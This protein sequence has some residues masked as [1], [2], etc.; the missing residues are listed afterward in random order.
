MSYSHAEHLNQSCIFSGGCTPRRVKLAQGLLSIGAESWD[1]EGVDVYGSHVPDP[2]DPIAWRFGIEALQ[3]E[4]TTSGGPL[5]SLRL[6]LD[7]G[8]DRPIQSYQVTMPTDDVY[9][10]TLERPTWGTDDQVAIEGWALDVLEL[11][12]DSVFRAVERGYISNG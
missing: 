1:D 3:F 2:G 10:M 5:G 4:L 8:D 12:T 7:C 6:T 11:V 9:A